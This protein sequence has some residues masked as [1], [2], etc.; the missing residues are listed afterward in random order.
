[1]TLLQKLE[2]NRRQIRSKPESSKIYHGTI[3]DF[4]FYTNY[5]RQK[6]SNVSGSLLAARIES[7]CNF[8]TMSAS[9]NINNYNINKLY[10]PFRRD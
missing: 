4:D 10:R 3:Y 8:N 9:K 5:P 1:M 6:N 2:E 7:D